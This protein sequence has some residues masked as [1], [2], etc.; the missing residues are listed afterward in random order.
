MHRLDGPHVRPAIGHAQ[1]PVPF[2]VPPDS[3]GLAPLADGESPNAPPVGHG[4]VR[5]PADRTSQVAIED[6]RLRPLGLADRPRYRPV[7]QPDDSHEAPAQILDTLADA[8]AGRAVGAEVE[9]VAEHPG[10]GNSINVGVPVD[11][12]IAYGVSGGSGGPWTMTSD[13]K[14]PF[15]W[16]GYENAGSPLRKAL[17]IE[18][19]TDQK[20]GSIEGATVV[21][22]WRWAMPEHLNVKT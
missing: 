9:A 19:E 2:I 17:G 6:E 20:G 1:P 22:Q 3:Q 21:R 18:I 5:F 11:A 4:G 10:K 12:E 13:G 16:T 15:I 14:A 7:T 8:E